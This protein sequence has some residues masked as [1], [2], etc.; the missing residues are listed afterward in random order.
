MGCYYLTASR[1]E[2]GESS[3]EAGEGMIF[4]SP[5]EVFLAFA[6]KKLG[7]HAR[8]AGAPAD[9]EA[10]HQ[11]SRVEK[12][13]TRVEEITREGQRPGS[14]ARSAGCCSTTSS[15]RRWPSTIW[16]SRAST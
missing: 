1:G 5:A 15:S 3:C 13:K 11:R 2:P 9:R 4:T 6:Q 8:V 7:V 10:R 14:H 16:R 12:D